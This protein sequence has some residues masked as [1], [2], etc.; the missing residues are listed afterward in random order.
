MPTVSFNLSDLNGRNGFVIEDPNDGF[1]FQYT[2]VAAIR[3]GDINGDGFTDLY[4][5]SSG[6]NG[7]KYYYYSDLVNRRYVVDLLQEVY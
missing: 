3:I 5:T 6:A 1:G 2:T 4:V 7:G